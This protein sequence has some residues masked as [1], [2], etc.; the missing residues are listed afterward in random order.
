MNKVI[1]INLGGNA[2]QLEEDSYDALRA[3]L[4]TAATRLAGNPDCDEI[5]SDIERA[6]A[7]K[8]RAVLSGYKTVVETREVETV[9][10]Q[11]GPIETETN[12]P[13]NA[14]AES[15]ASGQK[16]TTDQPG[17]GT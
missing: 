9:L 15:R 14:G 7:E 13:N 17:G 6:I 3:Y 8:F 10:K 16:S 1:T 4:D 2:Y 12:G 5:L 11:M